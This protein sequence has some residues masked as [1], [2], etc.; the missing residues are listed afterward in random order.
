MVNSDNPQEYA[1]PKKQDCADE[2]LTTMEE[3]KF[4]Y[5]DVHGENADL[6]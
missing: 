3:R 6:D 4:Q 2:D 5:G 1:I